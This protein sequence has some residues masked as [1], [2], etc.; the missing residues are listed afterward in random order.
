VRA[1]SRTP[2][3]ELVK[4]AKKMMISIKNVEDLTTFV[5][6]PGVGMETLQLLRTHYTTAQKHHLAAGCTDRV[7]KYTAYIAIVQAKITHRLE[8]Q[9]EQYPAS[10]LAKDKETDM[11]SVNKTDALIEHASSL[12]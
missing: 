10:P 9:E 4:G 12:L 6:S 3:E 5:D 2:N 1:E 8:E 11:E 7:E